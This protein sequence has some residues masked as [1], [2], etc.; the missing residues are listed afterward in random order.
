MDDQEHQDEANKKI[1]EKRARA[2]EAKKAFEMLWS[3]DQFTLCMFGMKTL[4]DCLDNSAGECCSVSALKDGN[5]LKTGLKAAG[6]MDRA[7]GSWMPKNAGS[8]SQGMFFCVLLLIFRVLSFP[9]QILG[10]SD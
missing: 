9:L 4:I 7:I 1:E 2:A 6:H 3:L 5:W 8:A 10:R